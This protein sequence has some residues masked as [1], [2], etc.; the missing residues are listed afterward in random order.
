MDLSAKVL[1]FPWAVVCACTDDLADERILGRGS[2]AVVYVADLRKIQRPQ[3]PDATWELLQEHLRGGVSTVA[4]KILIANA[5]DDTVKGVTEAVLEYNKKAEE[6]EMRLMTGYTHRNLCCLLGFSLDG[7]RKCYVYEYCDGGNLQERL[8]KDYT[9]RKGKVLP[10]L[11]SDHRLKLSVQMAR[12]IE[13]LHCSAGTPVV[14]RDIKSA[15]ILVDSDGQAK[16]AD[17]G[18][19]REAEA[20]ISQGTTALPAANMATHMSTK[21]VIGTREYMPPEYSC[22]GHVS[23]KVVAF[24]LGIVLAE[25]L[26][27]LSPVQNDL[28]K[29]LEDGV[30]GGNAA[31]VKILDS[32][33]G[34][35][36][37]HRLNRLV[38]PGE[39]DIHRLNRLVRPGESARSEKIAL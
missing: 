20:L 21:I 27:G 32:R 6:E 15:N 33:P 5:K 16:V 30:D 9:T 18:T 29:M 1:D 8:A 10:I 14:H 7:L 4:I 26:L 28:M 31:L 34:E 17:F 36:A 12:G 2:F 24:A 35:W 25:L 38:R 13:Y 37:I 3:V 39:W 19:V 23:P 22:R 11:S